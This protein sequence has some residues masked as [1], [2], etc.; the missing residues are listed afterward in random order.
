MLAAL[1]M[2]TMGCQ[3]ILEAKEKPG[4]GL[5][6]QSVDPLCLFPRASVGVTGAGSLRPLSQG[7][8]A[9]GCAVVRP[10]FWLDALLLSP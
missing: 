7:P 4:L 5:S 8:R 3:V 2:K 9:C 6:F 10:Y 1:N